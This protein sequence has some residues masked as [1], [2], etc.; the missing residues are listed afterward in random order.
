MQWF[1]IWILI[2]SLCISQPVRGLGLLSVFSEKFLYIVGFASWLWH[3]P[4][5]G[6]QGLRSHEFGLSFKVEREYSDYNQKIQGGE[7]CQC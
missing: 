6:R 5:T 1:R 3:L 7:T 4:G 2:D